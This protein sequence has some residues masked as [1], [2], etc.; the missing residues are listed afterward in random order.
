M[1]HDWRG[2]HISDLEVAT[3]GSGEYRPNSINQRL[4]FVGAILRVGWRDAEIPEQNLKGI[5]LPNPDDND[6]GARSREQI[7]KALRALEPNTWAS[8][9]YLIGLTT[10][11]RIGEPMAARV[12]WFDPKSGMIE[13]NNRKLTKAKKLHC[14]P[15]L[16]CLRGPLTAYIEGWSRDE[17]LFADAPRPSSPKLRASHEASKWFGRFSASTRLA[18]FFMNC[19]TRG[20]KRPSIPRCKK[21]SGR[22]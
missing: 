20:S 15:L 21:P 14:V 10:G 8:W 3:V 9:V 6:R 4:Q 7:L 12:G 5:I 1:L 13:V 19:A 2:L 17:Y 16:A 18:G 11:V 22:S